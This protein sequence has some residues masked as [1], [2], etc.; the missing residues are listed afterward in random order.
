MR[1]DLDSRHNRRPQGKELHR[2]QQQ[3]PLFPQVAGLAL[4]AADYIHFK[5]NS[6]RELWAEETYLWAEETYKGYER[7]D[8]QTRKN[9]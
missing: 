3:R 9:N 4:V 7:R 6:Q 2:Q 5:R 8:S 1:G